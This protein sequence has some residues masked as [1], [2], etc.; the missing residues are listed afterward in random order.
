MTIEVLPLVLPP[1]WPTGWP[2]RAE[3]K[4]V[5]AAVKLGDKVYTGWRHAD[6]LSHLR[7]EGHARLSFGSQEDQ[8]FVDNKG[9]FFDRHQSA[10]IAAGARQCTWDSIKCKMLLSEDVWDEDGTPRT[11]GKPYDPM[12]DYK[13][14]R[15]RR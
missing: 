5:K 12:A 3:H 14:R 13:A 4:I 2:E 1:P 15:N 8:G 6:I 7:H 9:W 10:K 11:P